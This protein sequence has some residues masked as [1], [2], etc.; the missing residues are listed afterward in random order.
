MLFINMLPVTEELDVVDLIDFENDVKDFNDIVK[1]LKKQLSEFIQ[2]NVKKIDDTLEKHE[3]KYIEQEVIDRISP[4]K[5]RPNPNFNASKINIILGLIESHK[6][7]SYPNCPFNQSDSLE[8]SL[9]DVIENQDV[10]DL[11]KIVND[12]DVFC[13]NFPNINE[14][15]ISNECACN[16]KNMCKKL[17]DQIIEYNKCSFAMTKNELTRNKEIPAIG[18]YLTDSYYIEDD[19]FE[20]GTILISTELDVHGS[21]FALTYV[22][23][24]THALLHDLFGSKVH[25][26]KGF[27][28]G[29]AVAM[30]YYYAQKYDLDF[31]KERHGEY[32][33]H[34]MLTLPNEISTLDKMIN[35]VKCKF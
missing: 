21:K 4:P 5:I 20:K 11:N 19:F 7:C 18:L 15:C 30:E 6:N 33:A 35:S 32:L 16:C 1:A 13:K 9:V 10:K 12:L 3:A 25:K 2:D 8:K 31:N 22:H 29:F 24:S 34:E 27:N 14:L 26:K 28:E 17:F 23:E